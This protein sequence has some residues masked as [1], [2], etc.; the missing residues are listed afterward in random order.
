MNQHLTPE[1]QEIEN[2]I[3]NFKSASSETRKKVKRII[4]NV[5]RA[6]EISIKISDDDLALFKNKAQQEGLSYEAFVAKILHN[7]ADGKLVEKQ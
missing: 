6:N 1:E 4:D 5:K 2:N 3:Q 7:Y